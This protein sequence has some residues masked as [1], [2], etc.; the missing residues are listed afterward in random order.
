MEL[1]KTLLQE[2]T[3]TPGKSAGLGDRDTR[4]TKTAWLG[5]PGKNDD[6][7]VAEADLDK[8]KAELQRVQELLYATGTRSLL[9]VFQALD[10][11]GKDGTIAHV[12]SGVNPQGCSVTSFK[13]PSDE[14]LRHDFLW[15]CAKALPE[16]GHIGIFNRSYYEEV[17]VVR[18]HPEL[19]AAQHLPGSAKPGKRLWKER[20]DDINAFELHL[21]RCGTR[22]VKFF[23][24]VS[25][26]EQRKRFLDRL[27]D[28]AK[29][30]K[31]S[32]ADVAE[33]EHFDEY[34][35]A[36]EDALTA[37]STTHSPWYVIPADHK[38]SMRAL[39]AG[40]VVHAV[41]DLG[42]EAPKPAI[43]GAELKAARKSLLAEAD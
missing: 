17:L 31:F 23:L 22:V 4:N 5:K 39:V 6:T 20:Y 34:M 30:W 26:A 3:V 35:A 2:L 11:A 15:R 16:R 25:K 42:L 33:R 28:P 43:S 27:D 29:Q 32:S 12:M 37:T 1:P 7:D 14:D 38:P 8:F 21:E 13:R 24:H 40:V 19:L 10:A 9:L 18:V 36:Y 41:D